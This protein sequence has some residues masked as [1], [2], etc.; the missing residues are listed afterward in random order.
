MYIVF[1]TFEI[2]PITNGGVGQYILSVIENLQNFNY[3]PLI[4]AYNITQDTVVQVRKHFSKVGLNCTIFHVNELSKIQLSLEDIWNFEKTSLSVKSSLETLITKEEIVGVEWCDYAGIGFCTFRDKHCN[5]QSVFKNIPMWIHLHGSREICDFTERY[6]VSLDAGNG[7]VLSNYAERLSLELADAWKTS[8]QAVADWY[9]SY[10]GIHNKVF[11]SPLP[12][13]KLAEQN[14]HC[15][16]VRPQLPLKI[17]CPGRVQ[18]LKGVD[19]VV[20]AGV[21]LCKTFPNQ[22]HITFAGYDTPTAKVEYT[23]SIDEVK[24]FIPEEFISHFSFACKFSAQ[25]YLEIAQESHLA[26]F[27]SRVETFCLAAHE[28]NWIGI[29]LILADIPA[30]KNYFINNVNSYKFDG[31]V[32]GL[33]L[34]LEQILINPE[35]LTK[36]SPQQ[37][38]AFNPNIF[39][40]LIA[41]P[42]SSKVN[43]NYTLFTRMIESYFEPKQSNSAKI[44]ELIETN[45]SLRA[46]ITAMETSKFWQIRKLWF[47]VKSQLRLTQEE[48]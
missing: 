5:S 13:R 20:Q 2:A 31:T 15:K 44:A 28:L 45:S 21:E 24:N 7:Y 9:T 11:V 47:K 39:N 1:P 42:L 35:L 32:P 37:V 14:S 17:L 33:A 41:L 38:E 18:Y 4:I 19:I 10:F 36:I 6:P 3:K 26:I 29:P 46:R 40:E 16:V 30:F 48:P 22:F 12:Y 27:A 23:S 43:A 25:Q 8:S 34:L